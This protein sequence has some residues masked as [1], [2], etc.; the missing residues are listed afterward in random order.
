MSDSNQFV[1]LDREGALATITLNRPEQGNAMS[2]ALITQLRE[3]VDRVAMDTAI[4][5]VVLTGAGRF[6]CVGGDLEAFQAEEQGARGL[7]IGEIVSNLNQVLARLAHMAKPLIVAV[8]GPAAGAGL[9]LVA[10]GDIVI[11]STRAHFTMAYTAVGLTPDGGTTW[12][13]PRLIGLRL[14][15]E[16]AL[17]NRRVSAEEAKEI[18]LISDVRP[19]EYLNGKVTDV[20]RTLVA[21][22]IGALA[23]TRQL[24]AEG[25]ETSFEIQL[26]AERRS[27]MAI[28]DGD[29][30]AEGVSAFMAKRVPEFTGGA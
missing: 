15:Q 16:L 24:L 9:G 28:A 17:T 22:S 13:L 6:F 23:A 4:R 2:L 1:R 19:P 20:S 14:T 5:A 26:A 21:G 29:D 12:L 8:N 10:I 27:I 3:I 7:L 30:V 18:G 25:L 11:A